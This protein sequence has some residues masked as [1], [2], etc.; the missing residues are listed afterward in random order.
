MAAPTAA[1]TVSALRDQCIREA[2][3]LRSLVHDEL[4]PWVGVSGTHRLCAIVEREMESERAWFVL[5][6]GRLL[7][8]DDAHEDEERRCSLIG[9][10]IGDREQ[11]LCH[12]VASRPPPQPVSSIRP[13]SHPPRINSRQH[14]SRPVA[15]SSSANVFAGAANTCRERCSAQLSHGARPSSV[16]PKR[17]ALQEAT[18][19]ED[20][21]D[22]PH[23][24]TA[25]KPAP[26]VKWG[27]AARHVLLK[28]DNDKDKGGHKGEHDRVFD[29]RYS[30]RA[31]SSLKLQKAQKKEAD[32]VNGGIEPPSFEEAPRLSSRWK[33]AL[34]GVSPSGAHASTTVYP[35]PPTPPTPS[36]ATSSAPPH[37]TRQ[38]AIMQ[39]PDD[40]QPDMPVTPTPDKSAAWAGVAPGCSRLAR[41]ATQPLSPGAPRHPDATP[42]DG[43]RMTRRCSLAAAEQ[44]FA[45]A[46]AEG[47]VDNLAQVSISDMISRAALRRGSCIAIPLPDGGAHA[48]G[49]GQRRNSPLDQQASPTNAPLVA[50]PRR[51]SVASRRQSIVCMLT[52]DVRKVVGVDVKDK[53]L[54]QA[55]DLVSESVA[56]DATSSF[57]LAVPQPFP[58]AYRKR[59]ELCGDKKRGEDRPI[60]R[61]HTDGVK[62]RTVVDDAGETGA[63][64]S[65]LGQVAAADAD[66]SFNSDHSYK[67]D[68]NL[69]PNSEGVSSVNSSV[70]PETK[71]AHWE[72]PHINKSFSSQRNTSPLAQRSKPGSAAPLL[73]RWW[74]VRK[75]WS[76]VDAYDAL[77]LPTL[78][79]LSLLRLMW[80]G[81]IS[82]LALWSLAE[83]PF[84]S[85]FD[86]SN[87]FSFW[88]DASQLNWLVLVVFC[89]HPLVQLRTI[90]MHR[91]TPV[92]EPSSIAWRYI[93]WPGRMLIDI[94]A[95]LALPIDIVAPT[96]GAGLLSGVRVLY[97]LHF[98][99]KM[100]KTSKAPPS[101]TRSIVFLLCSVM[102]LHWITCLNCHLA[103]LGD[104]WFDYYLQ[105]RKCNEFIS[106]DCTA[107]GVT[108]DDVTYGEVYIHALY[109]TLDTAS[110]RGSGDMKPRGNLEVLVQCCTITL[111][112]L[113]YSAIIATM[114][115][116][117]FN[118]ESTWA[119]HVRRTELI[120]AFMTHRK[121][122]RKLRQ[123]IQSFLD[124]QWETQKGLDEAQVLN[125]LPGTLQKQV[126]LFCAEHLIEKVPLFRGCDLEVST[127]IMSL[128]ALRVFI[129]EDRV[130][131]RGAWGDECYMID[132]GVVVVLG[133]DDVTH[134][135]YLRDGSYFGELAMLFGGLRARTVAAVTHCYCYSLRAADLDTILTDNPS[136]IG[137]LVHNI[138]TLYSAQDMNFLKSR[139]ADG[140][141]VSLSANPLLGSLQQ[142]L[143]ADGEL[144]ASFSLR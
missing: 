36:L 111:S 63:I 127:S 91:G 88:G 60:L 2:S 103:T 26:T 123:R 122:P 42:I 18:S 129:P 13:D 17:A 96:S 120:K 81:L 85:A 37:A 46:G 58:K 45:P 50:K 25:E 62:S 142:T 14:T 141:R 95:T 20:G 105:W 27:M 100:E 65:V 22:A 134:V 143:A 54:Q 29:C 64:P 124:Y 33:S 9:S 3:S 89:V 79:P 30:T 107:D 16:D 97:I 118:A 31:P 86:S 101:V 102:S 34:A 137:N 67:S 138:L 52:S 72:S 74:L 49:C 130:I 115:S 92:H 112:T 144:A 19:D 121:I 99:S 59:D 94:T 68:R 87:H 93:R 5:I 140:D 113:L 128:L 4:L 41:A 12:R 40:H 80:D 47:S 32:G 1:G 56:D 21:E 84:R 108:T 114:T 48:T 106:S 132:H 90:V 70:R 136:C 23:E 77:P 66:G 7:S 125:E 73:W 6:I 53:I 119:A 61:H 8:Q 24:A 110:T 109:W 44:I 35:E 104:S 83:V 39:P 116:L 133:E 117:C 55:Q 38:D 51:V 15:G 98:L 139:L 78:H 28:K 57:R 126:S 75:D 11:L 71:I 43:A 131:V 135:R 69:S 10:L 82:V 76:I